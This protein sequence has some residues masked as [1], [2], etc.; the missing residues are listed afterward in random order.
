MG[1]YICGIAC[2][3]YQQTTSIPTI[4]NLLL[5]T[6]YI[7]YRLRSCW[8]TIRYIQLSTT[9]GWRDHFELNLVSNIVMK[10]LN[11]LNFYCACHPHS[12]ST[13]FPRP[14][15]SRLAFHWYEQRLLQW[16]ERGL[17]SVC[18]SLLVSDSSSCCEVGHKRSIHCKVLVLHW[19]MGTSCFVLDSLFDMVKDVYFQA[20]T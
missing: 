15:F 13:I 18:V 9:A 17:Q 6:K 14:S 12:I 8:A 1:R 2:L 11:G 19:P 20:H 10:F 16:E 3:Q 7:Q 5:T 4:Y